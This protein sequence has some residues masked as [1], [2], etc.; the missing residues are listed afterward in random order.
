MGEGISMRL[1]LPPLIV[2]ALFGIVTADF[3]TEEE[4]DESEAAD[5]IEGEGDDDAADEPNDLDD[6]T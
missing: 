3:D 4:E 5:E 1:R 2:D 6:D